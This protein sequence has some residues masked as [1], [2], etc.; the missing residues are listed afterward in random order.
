MSRSRRRQ[1][2]SDDARYVSPARMAALWGV[3]RHTIYRDIRKG[4]IRTYRL[5]SGILRIDRD[6]ALQYGKPEE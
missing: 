5:P 4:A 3:S 2:D 6:E 1:Q